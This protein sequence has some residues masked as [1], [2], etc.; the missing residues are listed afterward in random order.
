MK[1]FTWGPAPNP[2]RVRI[3]VAEKGIAIATEDVG[4]RAQLKADFLARDPNRLT[5][6]LELDDGTLIGEAAAI[7]RYLDGLHPEPPL[8]GRNPTQAALIDMWERKCEF[9]GLQATAEVFRNSLPA[10][11]DRGLGGYAVS[12]PQIPALIERGR[13][14]MNAFYGKLDAQL[15]G[16]EYI[17]GDALSMADITGLCAIDF[18]IR[19]KI[20]IPDEC[21]RV[22]AWHARVS[23]RPSAAQT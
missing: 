9:E 19:V 23:A 5:P 11:V 15:A 8:F 13:V 20:P 21:K 6:A 22:K 10:F 17:V 12:I 16:G 18:A 3:F 14:R 2:R 7:C 1:L 4:E